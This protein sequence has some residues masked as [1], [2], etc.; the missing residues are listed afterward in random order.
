MEE[1]SQKKSEIIKINNKS[2]IS[3]ELNANKNSDFEE[4]IIETYKILSGY[5]TKT[6]QEKNK[7]I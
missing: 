2:E 1:S 7:N 6:N 4:H 5:Y 3:N